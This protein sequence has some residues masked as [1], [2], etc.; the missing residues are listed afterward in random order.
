VSNA[1]N[2][3]RIATALSADAS[4][5]LAASNTPPQ[6]DDDLSLAT[7]AFVR[8]ALGNLAG[9]SVGTN[10]STLTAASAGRQINLSNVST[11]TLPL[12]SAVPAGTAFYFV[13][14]GTGGA[15]VVQRQG[16]DQFAIGGIGNIN[17]ISIEDGGFAIVTS[18]G[19]FWNV[20]SS[21]ATFDAGVSLAA[22][23]Y[24][25]LPSGLIVQW[26]T[27]TASS[28]SVPVTFPLV[29]PSLCASI[30]ML[31]PTLSVYASLS[32]RST[33]G[34]TATFSSATGSSNYVAIG[35]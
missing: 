14:S 6:F 21:R 13:S 24:Q 9:F 23:G 17:S 4:K 11:V 10:G 2:L 30:T 1:E 32:V 33:S 26:G 25:R 5:N 19:S 20:L 15:R 3:A 8:R 22:S 35:Y 29:F 12:L 7:T 34:F 27:V 16:T 28:T 18:N 31:N